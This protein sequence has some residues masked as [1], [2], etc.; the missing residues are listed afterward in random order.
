MWSVTHHYHFCACFVQLSAR[1]EVP[2]TTLHCDRQK[3]RFFV[4]QTI[5]FTGTDKRL[6]VRC[7]QT[8]TLTS[9][10]VLERS[11]QKCNESSSSSPEHWFRPDLRL[12]SSSADPW[13]IR[14]L[15][16]CAVPLPPSK[17]K[18]CLILRSR[19]TYQ[20]LNAASTG[21]DHKKILSEYSST[22]FFLSCMT[23]Q[24]LEAS[25][26]I[27]ITNECTLIYTMYFIH[28]ILTSML[29]PEMCCRCCA[30]WYTTPTPHHLYSG[31]ELTI[32]YFF[33]FVK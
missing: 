15:H 33:Y 32:S 1:C 3:R 20:V 9:H 23:Y 7:R 26:N 8:T 28:N 29:R 22:D 17:K 11:C 6:V 10:V 21:A 5:C 13:R 16:S 4:M 19:N 24:R 30:D 25:K 12:A 2:L 18:A 27:W 31:L 14:L